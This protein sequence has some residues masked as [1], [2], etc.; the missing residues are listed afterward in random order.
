[1]NCEE[2]EIMDRTGLSPLDIMI[3]EI[4]DKDPFRE[5][6]RDKRKY[7]CICSV[8]IRMVREELIQ[9]YVEDES[10]PLVY[11]D[12]DGYALQEEA[13]NGVLRKVMKE[14]RNTS[15]K[16]HTEIR[17]AHK[18]LRWVYET[19]EFLSLLYVEDVDDWI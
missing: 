10:V 16:P 4:C 9:C 14:L 19:G 15:K 3:P 7:G 1:M 18:F 17:H 6:V 8:A 11:D 5:R 2:W 13:F 12:Y